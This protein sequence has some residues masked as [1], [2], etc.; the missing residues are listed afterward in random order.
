MD[1]CHV[2]EKKLSCLAEKE[3]RVVTGSIRCLASLA[4]FYYVLRRTPAMSLS[5]YILRQETTFGLESSW[6]FCSVSHEDGKERRNS[7]E[8]AV[9][10]WKRTDYPQ[11]SGHSRI[12]SILSDE[13]HQP[14]ATVLA[15]GEPPGYVLRL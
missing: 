8:L 2:A 11:N 13:S 5:Q 6:A 4:G 14:P 12:I 10:P 3:F 1:L 7:R 9:V 15:K